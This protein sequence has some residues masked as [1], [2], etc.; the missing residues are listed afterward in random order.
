MAIQRSI[1]VTAVLMVLV[2]VV[3]LLQPQASSEPPGKLSA[4]SESAV[5]P[6][7]PL[8][9]TLGD[10]FAPQNA[11]ARLD[12]VRSA[13]V[14]F[15]RLTRV[16]RSEAIAPIGNTDPETQTLGF[17]NWTG[18]IEGTVRQQA[19]QIS[20][21]EYELAQERHADGE[22]SATELQKTA[23][24]YRQEQQRFQAFLDQ[25]EIVD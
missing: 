7:E 22:I 2:P 19:Y 4:L 25:A 5:S 18:D 11:L 23:E 8:A 12:Q 10:R 1:L 14:S 9:V 6:D 16:S 21:L 24:R 17:T 13:L 20:K 3:S 15:R